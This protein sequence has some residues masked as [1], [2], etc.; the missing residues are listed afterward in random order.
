M[1]TDR[2]DY[3]DYLLTHTYDELPVSIKEQI[4]ADSYRAAR[5]QAKRLQSEQPKEGLPPAIQLAY[6]S[7]VAPV[8]PVSRNERQAPWWQL[9]AAVLL[10][11]S[12][13]ALGKFSTQP[14]E[15]LVY[16]VTSTPI[17]EPE[18]HVQF[19]T[20]DR[21]KYLTRVV[22]DTVLREVATE[23]EILLVYDTIRVFEPINP[24]VPVMGSSSMQGR[25]KLL[26]FLVSAR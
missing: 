24:N 19:D 3:T 12:G 11:L 21:V 5:L 1:T 17:P 18:T 20:I 26:E 4:D 13:W 25:E 10:L 22:Y 15:K 23:P 6:R 8:I 2:F 16:A 7:K 14:E 9:A